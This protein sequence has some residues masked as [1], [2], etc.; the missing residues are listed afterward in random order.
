[1]VN[2]LRTLA[3][4]TVRATARAA[5][6]AVRNAQRAWQRHVVT[7]SC[8]N[9][10]IEMQ[11]NCCSGYAPPLDALQEARR[12]LARNFRGYSDTRW[13][14]FY[15]CMTG[16]VDPAYIPTDIFFLRIEPT[17][18]A[19]DYVEVLT[20]K[21]GC[22]DLPIARYLPEPVLHLVRGDLFLPG[23]TRIADGELDRVLGTS[24]EEFVVKPSTE[25]GGGRSL[26]VMDG[27]TTASFLRDV[28]RD[29]RTRGSADWVVQRRLEQCAELAHFNPSSVN[30]YRITMMRLDSDVVPIASFFRIGGKGAK[31]DNFNWGGIACGITGGRLKGWGVDRLFRIHKAQP[32]S[33][34]AIAGELPAYDDAVELCRKLHHS[35][36][37][38]DLISWDVAIDARY[39]PRIIEFNVQDQ[40]VQAHQVLNGPLFGSEGS[41]ALSHALRKLTRANQ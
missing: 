5:G 15:W 20:D 9:E 40:G 25:H 23:F 18:N 26:S 27:P 10:I 34:I 32:D 22:Y 1:M 17:L 14:E 37:W 33:G 19:M 39:Q 38:F 35:L 13:H 4:R 29:R 11:R 6:E 36:P 28:I 7:E 30:C 12:F 21:N 8:R 16:L 24:G 3:G 2:G 41:A 31:V